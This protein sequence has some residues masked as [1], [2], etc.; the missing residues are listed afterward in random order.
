MKENEMGGTHTQYYTWEVTISYRFVIGK[1]ES[2]R[3]PRRP[4]TL[5]VYY[6]R[7]ERYKVA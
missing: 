2:K 4:M 6:N 5:D 7:S 3:R 1:P